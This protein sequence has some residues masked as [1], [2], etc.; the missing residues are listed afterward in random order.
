M[1]CATSKIT[2]LNAAENSDTTLASTA[3][4][5]ATKLATA[6]DLGVDETRLALWRKNGGGDLEPVLASGAVALLD[7]QWVISHAEAGGVLT[8]RQALPKEA[9]L[10]LADLVKATENGFLNC[11]LPVAAQA[12]LP[13]VDQGPPRPAWSQPQ[14]RRKGT[15]GHHRQR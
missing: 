8:H 7:A 13:V 1:G 14:P 2:T 15:Q 3:E 12:L 10:S 4:K 11:F 6:A 5:P 9:F